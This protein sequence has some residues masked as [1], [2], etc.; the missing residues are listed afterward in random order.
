M[1]PTTQQSRCYPQW[2]DIKAHWSYAKAHI[3][4]TNN[5]QPDLEAK[6]IQA[7]LETNGQAYLEANTQAD[8]EIDA[9]ADL[10]ANPQADLETDAKADLEA[11]AQAGIVAHFMQADLKATARA[12]HASLTIF[13]VRL[14]KCWLTITSNHYNHLMC[15]NWSNLC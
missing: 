14:Y 1:V 11:N 3:V 9:Q 12:D 6:F 2:S 8:L 5:T 13:E 15:N 4:K 10:E 7:D